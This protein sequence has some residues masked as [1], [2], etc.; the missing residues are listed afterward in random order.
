MSDYWKRKTGNP[1]KGPS[2]GKQLEQAVGVILQNTRGLRARV[3]VLA[4]ETSDPRLITVRA[5][6]D[7]IGVSIRDV[8]AGVKAGNDTA[9]SEN[10]APSGYIDALGARFY[11]SPLGLSGLQL[12]VRRIQDSAKP[13]VDLADAFKNLLEL[14]SRDRPKIGRDGKSRIH[15]K[16][17]SG[18]RAY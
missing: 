14:T 17:S 6:L 18:M 5:D 3:D 8:L 13:G 11:S 15:F 4:K 2:V 10:K 12:L 1:I 7:E 9:P 16:G